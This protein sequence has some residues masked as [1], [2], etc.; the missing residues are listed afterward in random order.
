[1]KTKKLSILIVIICLLL[2]ATACSDKSQSDL[3]NQEGVIAT[4]N[5]KP[6]TQKEYDETL[7]A[8]KKMIESTYGEG[9]WEMEISQG[10][11]IGQYYEKDLMDNMILELL[12]ID[13]AEKENITMSD[14]DLNNEFEAYKSEFTSE[15]EYKDFMERN[16]M[17]EEYLKEAIRKKFIIDNFYQ[18]KIENLKPSDSEL[19][20]IFKDLK[21]GERVRAS[22]ILVGTEDEAKKVKDRINKGE[23]FEDLAKELSTDPGSKDNG[24]DLDYFSYSEMVRPFADASFSMEIGEISEPVKTD[25]GY[26]IIK[27]TDKTKDDTITVE[28]QKTTLTD[29]Y[30]SFKYEELVTKLKN[31]AKIETKESK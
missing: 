24:G 13:A 9:A 6:I 11:T 10:Q 28:N 21:M 12:F 30:K 5:G 4:V 15:D 14:E 19:E 29:Y 26:H 17:T 25:F 27:V 31:D 8:Y 22:H 16:G 1:M 18:L 23:S 7:S 20:K 2:I 3:I